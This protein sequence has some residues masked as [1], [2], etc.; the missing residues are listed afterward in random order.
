LVIDLKN[1]VSY[2]ALNLETE[3]IYQISP[4]QHRPVLYDT[5]SKCW[6][7]CFSSKELSSYPELDSHTSLT[8]VRLKLQV[9][10]LGSLHQ[11]FSAH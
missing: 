11:N 8:D 5:A 10:P 1:R 4:P 9:L 7:L 3:Q 2:Q 6:Q